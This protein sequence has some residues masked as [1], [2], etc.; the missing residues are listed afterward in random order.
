MHSTAN[1]SSEQDSN[2]L[3]CYTYWYYGY[4]LILTYFNMLQLTTVL[5]AIKESKNESYKLCKSQM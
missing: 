4:V 1:L 2:S 3:I 5:M